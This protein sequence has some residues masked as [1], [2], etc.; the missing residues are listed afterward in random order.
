[1]S[2]IVFCNNNITGIHYSGY[3]ITKVYACGGEVV[4]EAQRPVPTNPIARYTP[5]CNSSDWLEIGDDNGD[6]AVTKTEVDKYVTPA[7]YSGMCALQFYTGCT[8]VGTGAFSGA[9]M[10][11]IN[12]WGDIT[13]IGASAFTRCNN[14]ETVYYNCGGCPLVVGQRA[15]ANDTSLSAVTLYAS[16]IDKYAFEYCTRLKT[17]NLTATTIDTGAFGNCDSLSSLTLS[18]IE[19]INNSAFQ[20]CSLITS[21]T[22]P[23]TIT[24]VG[25]YVF[26]FCT[27]L[28]KIEFK[29]NTPPTVNNK[30]FEGTNNCPIVIPAGVSKTTWASASGWSSY[31][32]RLKYPYE[33]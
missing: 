18:N 24:T 25:S 1:M 33:V 19:T 32:T 11:N 26:Y 12:S 6:S 2:K 9:G 8:E 5:N 16:T 29:G 22:I 3:T 30:T 15:F 10:V 27:S 14:L 13:T 31:A 28:T 17:V 23:S 7:E 20:G 4:Y 21:V